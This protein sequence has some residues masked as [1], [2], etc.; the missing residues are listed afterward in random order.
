M[1]KDRQ[2][3]NSHQYVPKCDQTLIAYKA[4]STKMRAKDKED[5]SKVTYYAF[6]G[7]IK[8]TNAYFN[9]EKEVKTG[10][11]T[12]ERKFGSTTAVYDLA[13]RTMQI[14]PHVYYELAI[15]DTIVDVTV[16]QQVLQSASDLISAE[17][18][19]LAMDDDDDEEDGL[20]M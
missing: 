20:G 4:Y 5:M 16:Q 11:L 3:S 14:I 17:M 7:L 13:T 2:K 8:C 18:D 9:E 19:G 6:P 15:E 1:C 12:L 10:V